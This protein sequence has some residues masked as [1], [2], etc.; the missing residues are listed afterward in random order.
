MLLHSYSGAAR[1]ALSAEYCYEGGMMGASTAPLPSYIAV[2]PT[3]T[4]TTWLYHVLN[5]HVG[6]PAG[7][8]ET[9]FFIWNYRLGLDW[10]RSHFRPCPRHL[11]VMEIA[12]T[13]FD[14]PEARERVK[15]HIPDCKIICTLRD[16]VARAWSHYKHWQQR[17][18][19][20]APFAE[21]AFTHGQI[22][23]AGRYADHIR[24]W[25]NDFGAANVMILLYDDLR[26]DP[27]RYLNSLT[28]FLAIAPIDLAR[29]PITSDTVNRAERMPLSR[30]SA[31]RA[32]KLRDFL[33]RRRLYS[34]VHLG[35]PLFQIFFN[36]GAPYPS[37]DPELELKL[38]RHLEPEVSK[39]ENLLKRDLSSWK[40]KPVQFA[41]V[42]N[43]VPR[44]AQAEGSLK[45]P[46]GLTQQI[47]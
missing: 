23:S 17:G 37:L 2:G 4:A 19:I 41:E 1:V 7:I 28:A 13:Y 44:D 5:G 12:P 3:R 25:Q 30:R 20:K 8:K 39:L 21:A 38:R 15:L 35:E 18:L 31:R 40:P 32:R 36:G 14:S 16:P 10:Y 33:I 29:S 26:A 45:N 46:S 6:L 24:S 42:S 22:V 47:A 34:L 9:Q 43:A 11:P 27:Q